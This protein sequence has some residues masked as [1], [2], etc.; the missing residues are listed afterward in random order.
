MKR[1]ILSSLLLVPFAGLAQTSET[2]S[3]ATSVDLDE[4]VV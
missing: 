4:L 2:D 1:I 3:V